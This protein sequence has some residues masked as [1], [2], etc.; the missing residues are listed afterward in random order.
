MQWRNRP[1]IYEIN[2]VV[3]INELRARYQQP[4]T[5]GN[6]PAQ[7]W[8][9][10][11]ALNADAVWFMGVWER[12]PEGIVV[13]NANASLQDEFRRAL[14]DYRVDDNVGSAYCVR[15]Y[16]VAAELGGAEGLAAARAELAARGLR[17][18]LD[19]VPNHVARDHALISAHPE[20]FVRGSEQDLTNAPHEFFR[21]GGGSVIANGRDPYFPPWR[22]VAQ[23]N[24]FDAG[25][26][27]VALETVLSI[28][29]QCDGM[30]CDMA[31]LMLNQIFARTWGARAGAVPETEY[32]VDLISA[33]KAKYPDVVFIA[34]AYWDLEYEL[35]QQGLDYCYDKKLYDFVEHGNVANARGHLSA[36][37]A[38]Q[39]KLVRFIE[40]HDEPR[41]A[42]TF[43][44][45]QER[46]AAVIS[47]TLPGAKLLY[48]G[49]LDGRK[50]KLPV[51]LARRAPETRNY[52]LDSFYRA[53][54]KAVHADL[55]H[56]GTWQRF[57]IHGWSD[58]ASNRNMLA[59]GW[60][61][62]ER[63]LLIVVNYSGQRS[64]GM[65]ELTW[66][67]L[68]GRVWRLSDAF[69][70]DVF[71]R[72]GNQMR[73]SGLYVELDPWRFHFLEFE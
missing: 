24:A 48:D 53:L 63:R 51:F 38:Y 73:D 60:A 49:Q 1:V 17:L 59:W 11:G 69:N 42:A 57:D 66:D 36:S 64:Q 13:S 18:I 34:E 21:G 65:V 2:T 52:E 71:I 39:D 45:P 37:V 14:P 10:L 23:L 56:A 40:N 27:A 6:V 25:L 22:D 31:M 9:T 58:N 70:G 30:R 8:D 33:V 16:T 47:T 46:A 35:M 68:G 44:A 62:Q 50:I 29:A 20:Y 55:F 19:F 7:E 12:S 26:R 54:L 32:W 28:A 43:A 67:E 4:L 61:F 5:L 41:A 72:D 3:W 15:A